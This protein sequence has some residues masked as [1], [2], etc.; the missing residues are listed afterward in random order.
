MSDDFSDR[1][2]VAKALNNAGSHIVYLKDMDLRP[3]DMI[4]I[5]RYL[6]AH[7]EVT[8]L[9][10]D[11]NDVGDEGCMA[12]TGLKHITEL[13]VPD[14]KI[15]D[16]GM[17]KLSTL[18]K[19]EFLDVSYNKFG[20]DGIDFISDRNEDGVP[21]LANLTTLRAEGNAFDD[22]GAEL[23]GRLD[24]L[25]EL[26]VADTNIGSAGLQWLALISDLVVCGFESGQKEE[27]F[28]VEA[29]QALDRK[30]YKKAWLTPKATEFAVRLDQKDEIMQVI[31]QAHLEFS[32]YPESKD[33][34]EK[35]PE[36]R[37]ALI[38]ALFKDVKRA[39]LCEEKLFEAYRNSFKD[40][41]K[42]RLTAFDDMQVIQNAMKVV[43]SPTR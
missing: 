31:E 7:P 32:T 20:N 12:L 19:L 11:G 27:K 6:N 34:S 39:E 26:Y 8:A 1:P 42:A 40:E 18:R 43:N 30:I 24:Q 28:T 15:G 3:S 16:D 22:D 5:V 23:L 4:S 2:E 37:E 41:S 33:L 10:L 21:K 9:Y 25:Q 13:S 38:R 29:R 17:Q 36:L 35:L 14:C